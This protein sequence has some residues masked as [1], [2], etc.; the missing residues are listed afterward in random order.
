ML[1]KIRRVTPMFSSALS[2]LPCLVFQPGG[3]GGGGGGRRA[4]LWSLRAART[5]RPPPFPSKKASVRSSSVLGSHPDFAGVARPAVPALAVAAVAQPVPCADEAVVLVTLSV[6]TLTV[7][8]RHPPVLRRA[9]TLAAVTGTFSAAHDSVGGLAE[10]LALG[11][12]HVTR[13]GELAQLPE[14][15]V[16][17]DAASARTV[18]VTSTD[19]STE[20]LALTVVTLAVFA[21][22]PAVPRWVASTLSTQTLTSSEAGQI[23]RSA[24]LLHTALQRQGAGQRMLALLAGPPLLAVTP[25]TITLAL[26]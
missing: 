19:L 4:V 23:G 11:V 24:T 26:T 1:L 13:P 9:D 18:A 12:A 5:S 3:G 25:A 20:V 16:L 6:V 17:A 2:L 14:P 22:N 15:A 21:V 10:L 7:L 8:S